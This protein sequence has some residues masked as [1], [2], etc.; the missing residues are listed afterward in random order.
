VPKLP[1]IKAKDFLRELLAFGCEVVAVNGSHHKVR[2][3][4]NGKTATIPIHGGKDLKKGLFPAIL[5]DLD[6]DINGFLKFIKK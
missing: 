6:I 5:K 4:K 1:V 2:N 3:V